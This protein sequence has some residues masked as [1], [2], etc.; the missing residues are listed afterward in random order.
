MDEFSPTSFT[1]LTLVDPV[2][3]SFVGAIIMAAIGCTWF[4]PSG[5]TRVEYFVSVLAYY[6]G[7]ALPIALLGFTI[8]YLSGLSRAAILGN[9]LPAVLTLIGGA[10][11]YI[12]GAENKFKV[13]VGFCVCVLVVTLFYGTESGA[14]AR[15]RG[16]LLRLISLSEQELAIR[17]F[18]SNRGL[19]PELPTWFFP[20]GKQ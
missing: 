20:A 12:F 5:K 18:R 13:A 10:T 14:S 2:I 7:F 11:I 9:I 19:S 16:Q 6:L 17:N 15:D 4:L 1:L 3:A 8:G